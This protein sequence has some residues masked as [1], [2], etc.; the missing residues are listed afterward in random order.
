MSLITRRRIRLKIDIAKRTSDRIDDVNTTS[1]PELWKGN[2]VQ[3]ELGF[4]FGNS[5]ITDISNIASLTL[6]IRETDASGD[7]L[8]TKTISSFTD[9]TDADWIA[10]TAQHAVVT[11]TGAEAN[12]AAGDHWLAIAITTTDDP[13]RS[14]T[15]GASLIKITEDGIGTEAA[16]Q[17]VEGTA[18][19]KAE[20][21]S[22]YV[23]KHEDQAWTQ[24]Y[25]GRWYHFITSTG[26]WYPETAE[27]KDGIPI[28]TLGEG[29]SI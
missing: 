20:T 21:D 4:Y 3:F 8:A 10:G 18:Y 12:I 14:V 15:L 24:F 17:A 27:I 26:L 5:I 13:G 25:N 23:Q 19:T 1:T 9:I 6:N 22:R 16:A 2:D 29:V 28:L 11:F 7:L